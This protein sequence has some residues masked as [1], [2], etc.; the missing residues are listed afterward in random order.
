M[1]KRREE[2]GWQKEGKKGKETLKRKQEE[3]ERKREKKSKKDVGKER[4]NEGRK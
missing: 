4:T 1:R 2:N 3:E